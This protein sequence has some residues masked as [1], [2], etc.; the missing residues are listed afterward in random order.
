MKSA[1]ALVTQSGPSLP[2]TARLLASS[3]RRRACRPGGGERLDVG[4]EVDR[5]RLE[6]GGHRQRVVE[7]HH[8]EVVVREPVIGE[9]AV[10][11]SSKVLRRIAPIL[12]PLPFA[13]FEV[14]HAL[15]AGRALR[16]Q[17]QAARAAAADDAHRRA[18][19]GRDDEVGERHVHDVHRAAGERGERVARVGHEL[20]LDLEPLVLEIAHRV[21]VEERRHADADEVTDVDDVGPRVL[22]R[23]GPAGQGGGAREGG[24]GLQEIT[25]LHGVL[26]VDD[27]PV[28]CNLYAAARR[29][30]NSGG[31]ARACRTGWALMVHAA[32]QDACGWCMH[33]PRSGGMLKFTPCS[34]SVRAARASGSRSSPQRST[35]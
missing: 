30:G 25:A 27:E 6:R 22:R 24:R 35:R 18:V 2:H 5:L 23:T 10:G 31:S 21:G 1:R 26:L 9:R 29:R 28:A 16:D 32:P 12:R 4:H 13:F 19:V 33:S 15:D 14:V 20:E 8:L 7:P 34:S 17:E 11:I 3:A